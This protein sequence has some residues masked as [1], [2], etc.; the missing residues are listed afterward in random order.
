LKLIDE[1]D[2]A[3]L[4]N[5]WTGI[6]EF[7]IIDVEI[8]MRVI[9]KINEV[10]DF[11]VIDLFVEGLGRF[12]KYASSEFRRAQTGNV[13]IYLFCMVAAIVVILFVSLKS[14]ILH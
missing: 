9:S 6:G 3:I 13:G 14:T 4:S 8:E 12:V 7:E 2:A 5:E 1:S 10:I 11:L